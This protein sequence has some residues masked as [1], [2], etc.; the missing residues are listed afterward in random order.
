[1][2]S[3]PDAV[4]ISMQQK[5]QIGPKSKV[6]VSM[7]WMVVKAQT[8]K[9]HEKRRN[10][11]CKEFS[12]CLVSPCSLTKAVCLRTSD[13]L[14]FVLVLL[15]HRDASARTLCCSRAL[16]RWGNHAPGKKSS[17]TN[18]FKQQQSNTLPHRC[19]IRHGASFL[20]LL[21]SGHMR[22][23]TLSHCATKLT[24]SLDAVASASKSSAAFKAA[25]VDVSLGS[26]EKARRL[27]CCFKLFDRVSKCSLKRASSTL[28]GAITSRDQT[29]YTIA[30]P[31]SI[32]WAS[33]R[34]RVRN[35]SIIN[36]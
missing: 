9:K 34:G 19:Q 32:A 1:M 3:G 13:K 5:K 35:G 16:T 23:H 27:C 4:L 22:D 30:F 11:S 28:T 10:A 31:F 7:R 14:N 6:K 2:Y 21:H 20:N 17:K 33:N 36:R 25:S 15:S 12:S 29:T 26:G 8:E 24:V 18:T